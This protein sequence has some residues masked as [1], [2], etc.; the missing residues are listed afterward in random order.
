MRVRRAT[1]QG[2]L[3][4]I[5]RSALPKMEALQE[6]QRGTKRHWPTVEN[7]LMTQEQLACFAQG[8]SYERHVRGLTGK[9]VVLPPRPWLS[10]EARGATIVR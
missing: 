7:P 1:H 10:E 8:Y 3:C 9:R 6:E 4:H 2:A 5:I